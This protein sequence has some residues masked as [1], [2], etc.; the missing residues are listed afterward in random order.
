[1][2]LL[3]NNYKSNLGI[4]LGN[5]QQRN[6]IR[7]EL[8]SFGGF[9]LKLLIDLKNCPEIQVVAADFKFDEISH[10]VL[11]QLLTVGQ[12]SFLQGHELLEEAAF[13]ES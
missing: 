11:D 10:E 3:N 5:S 6:R 1:M 9:F 8:L 7:L 13:C 4:S 2:F 12:V